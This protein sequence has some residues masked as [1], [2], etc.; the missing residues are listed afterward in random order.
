MKKNKLILR[1]IDDDYYAIEKEKHEGICGWY[2]LNSGVQ[3]FFS[4]ANI[5][6]ACVEGSKEELI[7]MAYD[8]KNKRNFYAKRLAVTFIDEDMVIFYSPKNS[9]KMGA[10]D[11]KSIVPFQID[12]GLYDIDCAYELADLIIKELEKNESWNYK[13][14][15]IVLC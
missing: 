13:K 11:L 8:I 9:F 4:S 2:E 14:K 15:E 5:S 3:S 12:S 6:D 7:E 1:K 10:E